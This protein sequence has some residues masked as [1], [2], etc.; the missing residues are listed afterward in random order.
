MKINQSVFKAKVNA[1]TAGGP[2]HANWFPVETL[3]G[4]PFTAWGADTGL[5]LLLTSFLRYTYAL[6]VY[7][8]K[9]GFFC[10]PSTCALFKCDVSFDDN[11]SFE[12]FLTSE[13]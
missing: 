6:H 4:D 10:R 11:T 3:G 13:V 5:F 8:Q 2:V 7:L 9:H 1:E 12:N